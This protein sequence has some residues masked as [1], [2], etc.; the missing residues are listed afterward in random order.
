[1]LGQLQDA[2]NTTAIAHYLD[3]LGTAG[4]RVVAIE[5]KSGRAPTT[6]PGIAAFAAAHRPTRTLLVGGGGIDLEWFRSTP[7]TEWL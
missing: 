4:T 5:V 7:V 3:L 6:L 1:M 2:G